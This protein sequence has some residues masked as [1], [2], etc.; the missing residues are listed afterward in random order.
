MKQDPTLPLTAEEINAIASPCDRFP[1][2]GIY[3]E[4]NRRRLRAPRSDE[5]SSATSCDVSAGCSVEGVA[6]PGDF[7]E[8][9]SVNKQIVEGGP[10]GHS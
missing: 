10:G 9:E 7:G 2:Q 8:S 1:L 4:G 3:G 5:V 6:H